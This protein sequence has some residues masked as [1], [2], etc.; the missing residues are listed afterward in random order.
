MASWKKMAEAFGR[1]MKDPGASREGKDLVK[2]AIVIDDGMPNL[3][4]RLD[5]DVAYTKG[6]RDEQRLRQE[7]DSDFMSLSNGN[8]TAENRAAMHEASKEYESD[9]RL[10]D[11]FIKELKAAASR[12]GDNGAETEFGDEIRAIINDL[13]SRGI[14]ETDIINTL[15]GE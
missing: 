3:S 1:A 12:H 10:E 5:R 14:S 13:K 4:E 9:K 8:R 7:V 6:R 15:K 11:E 2:K